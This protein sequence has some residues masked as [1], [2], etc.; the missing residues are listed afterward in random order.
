MSKI[1][2]LRLRLRKSDEFFVPQRRLF[3]RAVSE[4]RE[5]S[6]GDEVV[7]VEGSMFEVFKRMLA[8]KTM[9]AEH[10]LDGDGE[11]TEEG[12]E[13]NC[14]TRGVRNAYTFVKDPGEPSLRRVKRLVEPKGLVKGGRPLIMRE[15]KVAQIL[16]D[17]KWRP[18]IESYLDGKL[19]RGDLEHLLRLFDYSEFF[20]HYPEKAVAIFEA[21]EA[22]G[23]VGIPELHANDH[24]FEWIQ[25]RRDEAVVMNEAGSR[26]ASLQ[27]AA[28]LGC[29]VSRG[30]KLGQEEDRSG[31]LKEARELVHEFVD[32]EEADRRNAV[33]F[34]L[35]E[36]I[37]Q[38]M[39]GT[40]DDWAMGTPNA[41]GLR[42]TAMHP[43]VI[44]WYPDTAGEVANAFA[45]Q[46]YGD[47]YRDA[48]AIMLAG[49]KRIQAFR[50]YERSKPA[51]LGAL[52]L[53]GQAGASEADPSV[54]K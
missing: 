24:I 38:L 9:A 14:V 50:K 26:E 52:S 35:E 34:H 3:M 48:L 13:V 25:G 31:L 4:M 19:H 41:Y 53:A 54:P 44:D 15:S 49:V 40:N 30:F 33:A 6:D 12:G 36:G 37:R 27:F 23:E 2:C 20:E 1:F 10:W 17:E 7:G 18:S 45:R 16:G 43:E 5:V 39:D 47:G 46:P 21:V 8:A 42:T 28:R 22:N 29:L 11:A 51:D 32:S